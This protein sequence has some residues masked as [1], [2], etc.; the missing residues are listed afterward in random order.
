MVEPGCS[1]RGSPGITVTTVVGLTG[2]ADG[3]HVSRTHPVRVA[4]SADDRRFG[5]RAKVYREELEL[6]IPA[7]N[8][9]AAIYPDEP[10]PVSD[11]TEAARGGARVADRAARRSPSCSTARRSVAVMIDNQFRPTPASQAAAAGLRRDRGRRGRA[12]VVCANGKVFPMSESDIEQ[13]IGRENLDRMERWGSRSSRT[14]RATRTRT[15]I[16]GSP[17]AERRSGS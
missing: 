8:L 3:R 4:R 17:R 11:A 7:G 2:K 12:V 16:S 14:S 15:P 13:K 9:L 1:H 6:E 10:E 5:R